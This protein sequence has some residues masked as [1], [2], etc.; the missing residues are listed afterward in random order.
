[1]GIASS[2]QG[3]RYQARLYSFHIFILRG[4]EKYSV[5]QY[6]RDPPLIDWYSKKFADGRLAV[7]PLVSRMLSNGQ[8][9]AT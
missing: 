3:T 5:D 9:E 4:G 1:M 6:L 2:Q 7:H 8:I